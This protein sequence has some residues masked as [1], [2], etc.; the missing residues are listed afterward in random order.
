MSRLDQLAEN[1]L[2]TAIGDLGREMAEF[3]N[4]QR[5][6]GQSGV[7]GY[8][9][10]SADTWDLT[11]TIGSDADVSGATS[12]FKVTLTG[13]GSQLPF[14]ADLG[15]YLYVNG[16]DAAHQLTPQDNTWTDGTRQAIVSYDAVTE[17]NISQYVETFTLLTS[18]AITYYIKA[19]AVASSPGSVTVVKTS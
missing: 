10:Q 12:T 6:S 11:G 4:A 8:L 9:S 1:Y 3:K 17:P 16:T 13:D 7:L 15:F 2:Q 19:V 5:T 14:M 18:K